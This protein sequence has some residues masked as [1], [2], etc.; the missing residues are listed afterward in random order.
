MSIEVSCECAM[1]Y[2]LPDRMAGKRCRC[3]ECGD[4]IRVPTLDESAE[5]AEDSADESEEELEARPVKA[6]KPLVKARTRPQAMPSE[7]IHQMSPLNLSES[8]CID[9]P[10]ARARIK[11]AKQAAAT[12]NAKKRA[13]MGPQSESEI[14]TAPR[15]KKKEKLEKKSKKKGAGKKL[16]EKRA[17]E[18]RSRRDDTGEDEQDEDEESERPKK[19]KKGKKDKAA[20][21]SEKKLAKKRRG[22]DE[23]DDE[24][25]SE[26][27]EDAG[28]EKPKLSPRQQQRR[29]QIIM[30]AG[31]L[32]ALVAVA[33]IFIVINVVTANKKEA[34]DKKF[35]DATTT[36]VA[37]REL[38]RSS[39]DMA[40]AEKAY[41]DTIAFVLDEST[42]MPED[43]VADF[44]KDFKTFQAEVTLFKKV[45]EARAK[46]AG[47][48]GAAFDEFNGLVG[49]PNDL[50]REL[51]LQGLLQ[52]NDPRMA[53]ICL[54]H[55]NSSVAGI[56]ALAR[57]GAIQYG[58]KEAAGLMATVIREE[59]PSGPLGK[60]AIER[61]LD[62]RNED[63]A[64]IIAVAEKDT[65]AQHLVAAL[66]L[67]SR[68]GA[69]QFKDACLKLSSNPNDEVSKLA[70][71][72]LEELKGQEKAGK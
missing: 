60:L 32:G 27:S 17:F 13:A 66:N 20:D 6:K 45:G 62:G 24:N 53:Q 43:G 40:A 1:T 50:I 31:S 61:A 57:K 9:P 65:D 69:P 71:R 48:P 30:L 3:R 8:R 28:E 29:Q 19:K 59:G 70:T 15:P 22:R 72:V 11:K 49:A 38:A 68:I 12:A 33:I 58:G 35:A 56:K 21:K 34:K 36:V 4:S 25:D 54:P 16:E 10:A 18:R 39:S 64:L 5:S 37:A 51:G 47:D 23:E 42:P 67:M 44:V 2:R 63:P 55:A 46:L 41:T 14:D 7:S 26:D 52:T